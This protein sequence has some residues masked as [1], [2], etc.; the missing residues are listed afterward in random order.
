MAP[1]DIPVSGLANETRDGA[2]YAAL[3]DRCRPLQFNDKGWEGF[4]TRSYDG[5]HILQ[6]EPPSAGRIFDIFHFDDALP[7]LP[8]LAASA[9]GGCD[10]C[11]FLRQ[12]IIGVNFHKERKQDYS[13]EQGIHICLYYHWGRTQNGADESFGTVDSQGSD[14][15]V[16]LTAELETSDRHTETILFSV[17][18]KHGSSPSHT[19]V[20]RLRAI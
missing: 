4:H 10:F 13:D 19:D 8:K 15:L 18:S 6:F 9:H 5:R 2:G 14:G 11:G 16:A 1:T 3:C 17:H 7:G 20:L 12:S